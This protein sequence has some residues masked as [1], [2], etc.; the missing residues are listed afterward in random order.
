[1]R[2]PSGL[3][4][5][6][7]TEEPDR[8][9]REAKPRVGEGHAMPNRGHHADRRGADESPAQRPDGRPDH[10]Q[11][12]DERQGGFQGTLG[13][14][15]WSSIVAAPDPRSTAAARVARAASSRPVTR[16]MRCS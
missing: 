3:D 16:T 6:Q 9:L 11:R 4:L 12:V 13:L 8:G 5:V 7:G 1:M 2:P 14:S 10:A 15:T